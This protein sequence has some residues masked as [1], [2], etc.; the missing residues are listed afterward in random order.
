MWLVCNLTLRK[1]HCTPQSAAPSAASAPL[2]V[3]V[4]PFVTLPRDC[5]SKT[6][7]LKF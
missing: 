7:F 3:E 4:Q 2:F 5:F 6:M 1:G